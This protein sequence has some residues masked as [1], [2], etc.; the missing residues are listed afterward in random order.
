MLVCSEGSKLVCGVLFKS[1]VALI[2]YKFD[3]SHYKR[4]FPAQLL[5]ATITGDFCLATCQYFGGSGSVTLE[6]L[7]GHL[8]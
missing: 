4:R 1:V 8:F 3:L 6:S 5:T 7:P 2:H